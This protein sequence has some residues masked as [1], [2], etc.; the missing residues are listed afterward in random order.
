MD[1]KVKADLKALVEGDLFK[2]YTLEM[3]T[4]EDIK[5]MCKSAEEVLG[6]KSADIKKLVVVLYKASMDED[7]AK[8]DEFRKLYDEVIG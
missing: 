1:D 5:V 8:F 7:T 6:V 3:D 4:K 2:L